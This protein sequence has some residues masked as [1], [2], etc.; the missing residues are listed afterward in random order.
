MKGN[1]LVNKKELRTGVKIKISIKDS[2]LRKSLQ[3]GADRD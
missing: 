3:T 2:S 1:L